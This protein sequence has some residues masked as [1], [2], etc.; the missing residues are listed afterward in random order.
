MRLKKAFVNLC[1]DQWLASL[2]F[3]AGWNDQK[4]YEADQARSQRKCCTFSFWEAR[5]LESKFCTFNPP[6]SERSLKFSILAA[7]N[8]KP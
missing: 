6:D 1:Q 7:A 5:M 8:Q 3:I 2:K 4:K